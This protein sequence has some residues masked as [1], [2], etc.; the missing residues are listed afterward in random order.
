MSQ[1]KSLEEFR[2][3]KPKDIFE[4]PTTL[5]AFFEENLKDDARVIKIFSNDPQANLRI[6]YYQYLKLCFE[7]DHN[8]YQEYINKI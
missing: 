4:T 6:F 5:P 1:G 3:T 7:F 8:R 2:V